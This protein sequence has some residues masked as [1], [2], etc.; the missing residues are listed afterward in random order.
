MYNACILGHPGVLGSVIQSMQNTYIILAFW[1]FS[2]MCGIPYKTLLFRIP[3]SP[4]PQDGPECKHYCRILH[5]RAP[6]M[7][8][9][10]QNASI[11]KVFCMLCRG[12]RDCPECK[13]YI[14]ILHFRG[15]PGAGGSASRGIRNVARMQ[16]L[17]RYFA[18]RILHLSTFW[19]FP[20]CKNY[21]GISHIPGNARM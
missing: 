1:A 11:I 12:P 20:E 8:P 6:G 10:C 9:R 14:G 7:G 17:Q 5:F 13:N 2:G 3:F 19:I 16:G 21:V 4:G 15:R 18:S